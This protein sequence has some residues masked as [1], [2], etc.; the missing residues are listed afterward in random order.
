MQ[1]PHPKLSLIEHF[2]DLPDPRVQRTKDHDL[3]D[4]LV[5]AICT[6]LCAGESFNDM[7][8]FGKAK[9]EWFKTFL[10]LRNGIPSHDTFNRLFAALD[11]KAFL[12]CFVGWT[13][14][15]RQAVPQE[16]V[17]LDGKAL[18]RALNADQS[19]KYVVSAWAESNGLVLGQLKVADKSNEITALPELLRVLELSGCIVTVDAMGT[20]KKIAREIKEADADYVLALKG[21]HETVQAEVKTF[22]D[23][24][25][26][27][28]SKPRRI[29]TKL[30]PAAATLAVLETVEKDHGRIE[31]R[32]YYQ[33]AEVDWFADRAK[34]EGLRSVGMVEA[35]RETGGQRTVERRYYLT[36]LPLGVE[37]FAR[38]VRGH[39]GVE[40]KLHWVLDVCF[41]EDQSRARAG[42]A[43]ENLATLR[44]LALNLLRREKTKKRGIKGKQL[45]ASWNQAY[46]L[47]LLGIPI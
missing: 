2:K 15:L 5:I 8:D 24:T 18:R 21:N 35:V 39:W 22:L 4:I 33:S 20:Q 3:I 26:A 14:S 16:I 10:T 41:R 13:Q 12:D 45:N 6:L 47:R 40:N 38:A 32:R 37:T 17:A 23:E 29:G 46:L 7:E 11:P 27:E 25:V 34:W 1:N 28:T 31:T 44:R 43:A 30:S 42:N 9:R 36:S 19:V